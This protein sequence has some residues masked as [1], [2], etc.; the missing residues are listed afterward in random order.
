MFGKLIALSLMLV[1]LGASLLVLRQHRLE[2]AHEAATL[3]RQIHDKRQD[4]WNVQAEASAEL[5][6]T[7]LARR[8]GATRLALEP[9]I[10]ESPT[11]PSVLAR[12]EQYDSP[13]QP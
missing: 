3:H 2:L 4:I 10:P 6:P 7:A 5:T 12:S 8:I 11:L 1:V 9:H 13:P